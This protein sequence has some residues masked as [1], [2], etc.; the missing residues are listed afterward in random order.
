MNGEPKLM[1]WWWWVVV[2]AMVGAAFAFVWL[3]GLLNSVTQ[4]GG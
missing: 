2:V 1:S 4:T 3:I